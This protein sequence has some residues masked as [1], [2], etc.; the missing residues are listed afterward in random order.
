MKDAEGKKELLFL[1]VGEEAPRNFWRKGSLT[2][3]GAALDLAE[4]GQPFISFFLRDM[5]EKEA[6]HIGG[7]K[8]ETAYWLDRGFWLGLLK[9]GEMLFEITFD[10]MVHYLSYQG[11]SRDL[12]RENRA[13]T[14]IGIDTADMVV[15]ALRASTYPWKFLSGLFEAFDGFYPRD[16]YTKEYRRLL[17]SFAPL[18]LLWENFTPGGYFGEKRAKD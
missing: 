8:I 11:F 18:P 12:F 7:G 6:E 16:S 13:V 15:R 1:A 10:P 2:A 4:D 17:E 9:I 5:T 14:I 3:D